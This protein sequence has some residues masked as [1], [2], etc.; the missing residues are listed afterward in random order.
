MDDYNSIIDSFKLDFE[1][2]NELNDKKVLSLRS[3]I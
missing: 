2:N 1:T 3:S